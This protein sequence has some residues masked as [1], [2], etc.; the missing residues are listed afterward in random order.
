MAFTIVLLFLI[1]IAIC[2]HVFA[3]SDNLHGADA[4]FPETLD[5]ANVLYHANTRDLLLNVLYHANKLCK[6]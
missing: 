4:D 5:H 2:S 6:T 3:S 1:A